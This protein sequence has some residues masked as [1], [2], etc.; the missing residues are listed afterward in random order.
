VNSYF[1]FYSEKNA[2]PIANAGGDQTITLPISAII[3]NGTKSSDDLGIM[4]Y[5]WTREGSSLAIGTII[6]NSDHEAVLM[7]NQ[8][9]NVGLF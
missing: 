7:V 3:M 1:Q 4:N 9:P 5:S 6:G 2:A 8:H